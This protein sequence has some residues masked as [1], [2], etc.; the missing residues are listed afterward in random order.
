[1]KRGRLGFRGI[2]L[3]FVVV[4]GIL[5]TRVA[6]DSRRALLAGQ[7]AQTNG[8]LAKAQAFYR[9]AAESYFPANPYS[10]D[11]FEALEQMAEA[12]SANGDLETLRGAL[13]AYRAAALGSRSFFIPHEGE[14]QSVNKQLAGV[15][16]EIEMNDISGTTRPINRTHEA[17][18]RWHEQRLAHVPGPSNSQFLL[19]LLG[20]L[21]W[22]SAVVLFIRRGLGPALRL[23]R[24]PALACAVVFL[25]GFS[26]F[27]LG[28]GRG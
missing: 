9:H 1:M 25:V 23:R 24:R 18:R 10:S 11:A 20:L 17:L 21:L 5:C 14:L 28:L 13:S 22:V 19:A 26:C 3:L 2:V 12:A 8:Q 16:T 7:E 15:L 6:L 27:V 4:L